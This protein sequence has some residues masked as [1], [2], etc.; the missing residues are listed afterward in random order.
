LAA[1]LLF[2]LCA[3]FSRVVAVCAERS[4]LLGKGLDWLPVPRLRLGKKVAARPSPDVVA[5]HLDSAQIVCLLMNERARR[6]VT[7][8]RCG[9]PKETSTNART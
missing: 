2:S 7:R 9:D 3:F 5:A 1:L 6:Y 4:Q 8:D